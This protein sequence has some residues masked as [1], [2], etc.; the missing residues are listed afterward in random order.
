MSD[1]F[2]RF[3][4]ECRLR[5]TAEPLCVAPRDVLAPLDAVEQH[6]LVELSRQESDAGPVRLIFA[7]PATERTTPAMR[8]VLW[9]LAGDAWALE[10]ADRRLHLWAATYG[11][12]S[13]EEA[14]AWLFDQCSRQSA[15]LAELLGELDCR[16]L[17]A[18]YEAEMASSRAR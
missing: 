10:Q 11:Y 6:F 18:L 3:A 5:L 13:E 17:L 15:A 4:D 12:P 16:R 14:T 2:E 1:P 9:W 7:V 8:D